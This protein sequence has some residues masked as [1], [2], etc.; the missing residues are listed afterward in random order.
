MSSS[1]DRESFHLSLTLFLKSRNPTY[2]PGLWPPGLGT[3]GWSIYASHRVCLR[4]T[5]CPRHERLNRLNT[6][7]RGKNL[8]VL[9]SVKETKCLWKHH[10][11]VNSVFLTRQDIL[12]RVSNG[13]P[14]HPHHAVQETR[15][16]LLCRTKEAVRGV[17]L[18]SPPCVLRVRSVSVAPSCGRHK[19]AKPPRVRPPPPRAFL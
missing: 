7:R 9:L 4:N 6:K 5:V 17:C 13:P 8:F 14:V 10:Y 18:L 2:F 1:T 12:L 16:K 11:W 19:S 15:L 3:D